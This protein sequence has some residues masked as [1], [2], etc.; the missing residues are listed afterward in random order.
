MV[1]STGRQGEKVVEVSEKFVVDAVQSQ[2]RSEAEDE[3]RTSRLLARC[4]TG[5]AR[6]LENAADRLRHAA[7]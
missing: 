7:R 4:C 2:R 1:V 6:V 3:Q 5:L